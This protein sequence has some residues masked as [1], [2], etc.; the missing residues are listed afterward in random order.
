MSAAKQLTIQGTGAINLSNI[1]AG[2]SAPSI[3]LPSG[4]Y[5]VTLTSDV[6]YHDGSPVFCQQAILFNCAPLN[7]GDYEKW[8]Y[9]LNTT[10]GCIIKAE[11]NQ[12]V[13]AF[14]VDQVNS[15][16]NTGSATVTFTPIG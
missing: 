16:D 4:K 11:E 12:P 3:K 7:T 6:N 1:S 10:E 8:F 14:I 9:V 15:A 2:G 13:Y 5:A